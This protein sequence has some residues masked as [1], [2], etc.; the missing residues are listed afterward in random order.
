MSIGQVP[1]PDDP[2]SGAKLRTVATGTTF[3]MTFALAL[4]AQFCVRDE[5][6]EAAG[7][8]S[9]AGSAAYGPHNRRWM[10]RAS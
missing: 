4:A 8:R 9:R 1:M 2:W 5:S 6:D 3:A 10:G 7:R